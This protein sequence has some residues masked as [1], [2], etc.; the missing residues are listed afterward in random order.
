LNLKTGFKTVFFS[1]MCPSE[2]IA[3]STHKQVKPEI[4]SQPSARR[5]S[6]FALVVG[7]WLVFGVLVFGVCFVWYSTVQYGTVRYGTVWYGTTV[8]WLVAVS[9]FL[10]P[11][12]QK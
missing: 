1:V 9:V 10:E 2:V 5:V 8:Q 7:G 11:V 12:F 6:R 4:R 3:D